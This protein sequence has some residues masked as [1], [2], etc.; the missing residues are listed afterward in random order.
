MKINFNN[1][2]DAKDAIQN[3]MQMLS[4]GMGL[5]FTIKKG[6]AEAQNINIEDKEALLKTLEAMRL[7]EWDSL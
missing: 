4:I 5:Y 3:V 6:I 1:A 7:P 2:A